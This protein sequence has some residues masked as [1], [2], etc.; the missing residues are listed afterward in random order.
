MP[1]GQPAGMGGR[2]V[3]AGRWPA[4]RTLWIF[5][6]LGWTVSAADTWMIENKVAFLADADKPFALCGLI[7]GLF[8]AGY[9]LT[10]FPGGWLGDRY[11][12]RTIIVISLVWAGL[13]TLVLLVLVGRDRRRGR[14]NVT[15]RRGIGREPLVI[16]FTATQC[17]LTVAFGIVIA[18]GAAL[19]PF[20]P[21]ADYRR[22]TC[23]VTSP[24]SRRCSP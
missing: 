22:S 9:M 20:R 6:L 17:V 23:D 14:A 7:G 4:Y 3:R 8:F 11:G 24:S 10:Q 15:M 19:P 16:A 5:L 1:A 21:D 18:A 2:G 13:A 12:H